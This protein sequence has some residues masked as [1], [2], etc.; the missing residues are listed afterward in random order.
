MKDDVAWY[1]RFGDIPGISYETPA[2]LAVKTLPG[3]GARP[4]VHRF[5]SGVSLW[6]GDT[7]ESP[8]SAHASFDNSRAS[9][10]WVIQR[11]REVLELPGTASDYHF[12]IA[13]A[14]ESL[15]GLRFA[16]PA[17][18]SSV[19]G[20]CWLDAD[21]IEARPEAFLYESA[22]G[23]S[24]YY[25]FPTLSRLI[26][27]YSNEG[28]LHEALAVVERAERFDQARGQREKILARIAAIEAEDEQ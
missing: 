24:S 22:D 21:L 16:D 14:A 20:F 19:E 1:R 13:A 25:G 4:E 28:Y 15:F 6:W 9:S 18:L 2:D 7:T 12:A 8:A 27:L 5:E 3:Y 11:L 23:T 17:A 10:D 26:A